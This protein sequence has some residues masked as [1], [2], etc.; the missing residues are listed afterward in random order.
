MT[1]SRASSD[2][3]AAPHWLTL[4]ALWSC[5]FVVYAATANYGDRQI[6]DNTSVSI[7]SWAV[8]QHATLDMSVYSGSKPWS[9][10][11]GDESIPI[12]GSA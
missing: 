9:V 2:V 4:F 7:S 5:I 8:G 3:P 1:D 12:E 10:K 11:V 6:P